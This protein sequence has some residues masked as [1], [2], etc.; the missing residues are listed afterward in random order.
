MVVNLTRIE[1]AHHQTRWMDIFIDEINAYL[2]LASLIILANLSQL[3]RGSI[4]FLNS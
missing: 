2:Q 3:A 1:N 4:S